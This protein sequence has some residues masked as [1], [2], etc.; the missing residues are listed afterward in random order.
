[1]ADDLSFSLDGSQVRIT[2]LRDTLRSMEK[3]GTSAGDLKD[4][5]M[6]LSQIVISAARPPHG[7]TGAL[8]ASVRP[9]RGKTKAV[10]R[11]GSARVPYAGVIHYGWPARSIPAQPFLTDAINRTRSAILAQLDQGIQDL[12]HDADLT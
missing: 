12:L 6:S 7:D 11:A 9:G 2:G 4:L 5:M 8:S 1:M 3:A 10:I